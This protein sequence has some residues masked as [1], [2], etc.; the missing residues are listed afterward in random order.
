MNNT[1]IEICFNN[2]D[3][4]NASRVSHIIWSVCGFLF[5]MLGIP[6]N[7][8]VILIMSN[9]TNR[10]G[11]TSLYWTAIA[12]CEIIFLTGVFWI[13]CVGMSIVKIDP[14]E[15]F[16][17]GVFYSILMGP[18]IS[19]NLYLASMSI[20]RVF[21][22]LHPIR[23]RI[24]DTR[25]HV[26]MRMLLIFIIVILLMFP[27]NFYFYYD[28]KTTIFICEFYTH[29][30]QWKIR[31]WP[32]IHAILFVL[33][34]SILTCI[35][36]VIILRNRYDHRKKQKNKLSESARQ[37]E[38]NSVVLLCISIAILFSLLP[39]VILQIFIVHD[40]LLNHESL[41]PKRWKTYRILVNWFWILSVFVYSCKFYIRLFISKTFRK[42]FLKLI[43]CTFRQEQNDNEQNFI[44]L[45]DQNKTKIADAEI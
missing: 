5:T 33:C 28:S 41:C 32:F 37:M 36:A 42:D 35:A 1:K 43:H 30:D 18:T 14:R 7:I 23:Y 20:D 39:T 9:K 31:V 26:I 25:R 29:I 44:S 13:W 21:M 40:L 45:N 22:I 27:L 17:C 2:W 24:M 34:P 8:F 15:I 10:K 3:Y 38:R 12:I 16:S 19:S 6:G 4:K 11:S